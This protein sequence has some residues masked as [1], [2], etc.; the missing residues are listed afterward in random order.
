MGCGAAKL[1]GVK[2]LDAGSLGAPAQGAA[3]AVVAEASAPLAEPQVSC[4]GEAV[5][6]SQREVPAESPSRVGIYGTHGTLTGRHSI[7]VECLG[8]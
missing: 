8:M 5:P 3:Q 1:V 6:I 7:D 4:V 2:A